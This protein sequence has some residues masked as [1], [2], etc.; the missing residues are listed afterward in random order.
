MKDV[1]FMVLPGITSIPSMYVNPFGTQS[2]SLSGNKTNLQP[3]QI[4]QA[5]VVK[6]LPGQLAT[7]VIGGLLL[8][9]LL[10]TPLKVGQKAWLEVQSGGE[11]PTL[12]ILDL[13]TTS[14][15]LSTS[16]QPDPTLEGLFN[17]LQIDI[18]ENQKEWV[19]SLQ[20]KQVPLTKELLQTL[21][22]LVKELGATQETLDA[23]TLVSQKGLPLTKETVQSVK[24][25]LTNQ[26]LDQ[27]VDRL[28]AH[29]DSVLTPKES[30]HSE[31]NGFTYQLQQLQTQLLD[32]KQTIR[33]LGHYIQRS[34]PDVPVSENTLQ[35][36]APQEAAPQKIV[37][38]SIPIQQYI[39]AVRTW[40]QEDPLS[41]PVHQETEA[42]KSDPQT[43]QPEPAG[44]MQNQTNPASIPNKHIAVP[45]ATPQKPENWFVQFFQELGLDYETRLS[46]S[47]AWKPGEEP[48]QS[49]KATLLQILQNPESNQLPAAMK[50]DLQ[51]LAHHITGQQLLFGTDPNASFMQFSLQL[52]LPGAQ[53][54]QN[55]MIHI[56]ARKKG[57][58]KID[59][60]NC[61]L[62]FYL[63]MENIGETI[64]DV[65]IVNKILSVTL[66][67]DQPWIEQLVRGAQK[68]LIDALSSQGYYLS[69]FT[70]L[71]V[72]AKPDQF[73]KAPP[74]SLTEY[75]GV[76]IKI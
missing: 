75:K 52:P 67:N 7:V 44:T 26:S 41:T 19:Q 20:D 13:P 51:Q 55:A 32:L 28:L 74:K 57:N 63:T 40:L 33:S 69:Q 66:Y 9:A 45:V 17:A 11:T 70:I 18:E 3:G 1:A 25:F 5:T 4:V 6:L 38:P 73:I 61:R 58:G 37:N 10:E 46:H 65:N 60:E 23:M 42:T 49:L 54:N 24:A 68:S 15:N 53:P 16:T 50:Q 72:P 2:I 71:P 8:T 22:S 31:I 48:I 62:F 34:E 64:L 12:K 59:T 21:P 43:E 27:Q 14:P 76:D 39:D 29:L 35:T 47:I 36:V 30:E 56:E